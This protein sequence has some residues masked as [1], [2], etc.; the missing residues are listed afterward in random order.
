MFKTKYATHFHN[1]FTKFVTGNHV[2][3][4]N[5]HILC[6]HQTIPMIYDIHHR[7]LRQLTRALRHVED[8]VVSR[9]YD[10]KLNKS[11]GGM[12]N[13]ARRILK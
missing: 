4:L 3:S 10:L 7:F 13:W 8:D 2:F 12:N 5:C 1:I 9:K 6:F 11:K